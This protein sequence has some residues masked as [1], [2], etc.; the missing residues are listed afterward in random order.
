M[1]EVVVEGE[2]LETAEV[3]VAEVIARLNSTEGAYKVEA[4]G[5]PRE[6]VLE[7]ATNIASKVLGE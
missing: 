1:K 5:V 4:S 3:Q 7:A 6:V 2:F